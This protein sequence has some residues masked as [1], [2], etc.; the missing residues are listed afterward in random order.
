MS[1]MVYQWVR[2]LVEIVEMV[3][4][5]EMDS[6]HDLSPLYSQTPWTPISLDIFHVS[7]STGQGQTRYVH[8]LG[9]KSLPHA[10]FPAS[11]PTMTTFTGARNRPDTDW[12]TQHVQVNVASTER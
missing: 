1:L 2:E 11:F 10:L 3:E 6:L 4:M 7:N 12:I 9:F 8:Q 5:A